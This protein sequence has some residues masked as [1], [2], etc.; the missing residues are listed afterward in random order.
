MTLEK[1]NWYFNRLLAMSVLEIFIRIFRFFRTRYWLVKRPLTTSIKHKPIL[2]KKVYDFN[3]YK[4]IG[5]FDDDNS[6]SLTQSV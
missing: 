2:Y 3:N 1:F 5:K 6:I 4:V